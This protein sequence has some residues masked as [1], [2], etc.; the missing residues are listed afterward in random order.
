[1][2]SGGVAYLPLVSGILSSYIKSSKKIRS[3]VEVQPFLF[4][5][6][7]ADNLLKSYNNPSVA[8]FSIAM[9]NENLSLKLA[10]QV[11]LLWPECL[12]VFGGSQ[13]PHNATEYM[14]NNPFIDICIR[15][16]GEDAFFSIINNVLCLLFTLFI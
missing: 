1:M 16:E 3:N 11:K 4:K 14:I 12:I 8:A 6:D 5:P 9:W 7:L 10:E 15:A 2:G 13:C